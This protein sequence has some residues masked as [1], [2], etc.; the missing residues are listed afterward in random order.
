M[1]RLYI[2]ILQSGRS[3][4]TLVFLGLPGDLADSFCSLDIC[5]I[6]DLIREKLYY[7][8]SG[9]IK[10]AKD[11]DLNDWLTGCDTEDGWKEL[12]SA[13]KLRDVI[14]RELSGCKKVLDYGCGEGW[15][16]IS[17]CK[18]GC[19]DVTGVDVVENAIKF[20]K[21]LADAYKAGDG[22]KAECVGTD[23][24][25][26]EKEATYDGIFCS[27]VIDVLPPEVS[28]D[29]IQNIARVA[30]SD[31]KI[32]ISMNYFKKTE[33]NPEKDI[34]VKN[35]IEVYVNGVLRLVTRTDEE[36][37]ERFSKYF[38]VEKID[39]FAWPGEDEE[40]RRIFIMKKK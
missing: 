29:I 40:T 20:A 32:V 11:E 6:V 15:A 23:W 38:E 27:N 28:D 10:S 39:Y 1:E 34:E 21:I 26:K 9:L 19:K 2:L 12:A 8:S 30:T 13:D 7:L 5:G 4:P 22:F 35:G 33:S 24:I 25:A 17:L 37:S 3:N 36:W 16:A 18:S 31:A 14:I